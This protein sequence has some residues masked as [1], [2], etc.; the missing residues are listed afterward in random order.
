LAEIGEHA[1]EPCELPLLVLP[2]G[3]AVDAFA[4]Q[5]PEQ[6]GLCDRRLFRTP[7]EEYGDYLMA[8]M[9]GTNDVLACSND[10]LFTMTPADLWKI[11]IRVVADWHPSV[12]ALVDAAEVDAAFP[13]TLRTCIEVDA[14]PAT[15][16]TLLGDAIH[17]MTPAA[18][19]GANTALRVGAH[20]AQALTGDTPLV[21]ALASYQQA[22][23]A[24]G[25][26]AVTES[27]ENAERLF[28][29]KIL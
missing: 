21:Q 13:I 15:R 5:Q 3:V 28:T 16:V 25:Q 18:G 10:E 4:D 8:V 27:L 6:I 29:L 9:T 11:V 20:L 1:L 14:W 26:A 19:A 22:M 12:R 2:V 17:P 24:N 7:P 23:I